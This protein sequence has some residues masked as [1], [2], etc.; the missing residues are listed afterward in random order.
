V[1]SVRKKVALSTHHR[2]PSRL[3]A[4]RGCHCPPAQN[5]EPTDPPIAT[6]GHRP[7]IECTTAA[8]PAL[9]PPM[10]SSPRRTRSWRAAPQLP[11]RYPVCVERYTLG[12]FAPKPL[13]RQLHPEAGNR[14]GKPCIS[15]RIYS[16]ND[17]NSL[18]VHIGPISAL[19][20]ASSRSLP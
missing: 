2:P 12:S 14:G 20:L 17:A 13:A 10:G 11:R 19:R 1:Q 5:Q 16:G 7:L 8:R 4:S 9:W 3:F 6:G 15:F 18:H